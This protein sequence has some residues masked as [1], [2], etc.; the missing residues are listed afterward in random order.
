[1]TRHL[2]ER[3]A[4]IYSSSLGGSFRPSYTDDDLPVDPSKKTTLTIITT[5][6]L[7]PGN[8]EPIKDAALV[9]SSK[10]IAWVG[11][12]SS[13]PR[14]YTESPHKSYSIP[15]LMP[16]LW[17]CHAHFNGGSPNA[18]SSSDPYQV[19]ITEHPAAS[20]ARLTRMC[21]LALQRGYTSLRDVAGMGCEISRAIEDGTIVGPNVYSSGACISQ[22]A[23]HG[24]VFSLPAGDVLLNL[25]CRRA[26][27]LQIRRGAKCIKVMA[28]GGVMSRD[29][30]PLYAQFSPAELETIVEEANRQ[31]RVVAAHVHG[32]PGIMA[33]IKAGV[34]TLEHVSFAD[35]ECIDLIKEKGI[36]YI[37]TRLVMDLLLG[38]GGKGIPP[39]AWEKAKLCATNHLVA[40]KMAIEA[41][42]PIALGTD[43]G[44]GFN[45][46]M[47]LEAAVKAGMSNLEAI[48]AATANGPLSVGGQAPKTGQLKAGYEADVLGLLENPVQDVRVLQ[49]IENVAWVWKGG[50]LFKG[51]GIGP[52]GE[53][54]SSFDEWSAATYIRS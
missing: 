25:G 4:Q 30:N 9:I 50:S 45:M 14:E 37:A 29:D 42:I 12:Q 5:S 49:K 41:G 46:A 38:T 33:A 28:S 31:N 6:L 21:W 2:I 36:I 22:L 40:Y 24:D 3:P 43:T 52:W 34:T 53:D 16:G 26:V 51:P 54:P 10:L 48:K 47:E 1:M 32:K 20:G 35:R 7:I 11:P 19:F 15:Y 8:G 39:T 27:R 18:G 17:D 23:G 44:P 13:I